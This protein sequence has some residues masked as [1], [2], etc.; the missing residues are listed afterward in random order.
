MMNTED[1]PHEFRAHDGELYIEDKVCYCMGFN[2]EKAVD[3]IAGMSVGGWYGDELA[4]CPKSA[5]EMAI[6]EGS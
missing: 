6:E 5:V 2:D 3:V 4:R 1:I